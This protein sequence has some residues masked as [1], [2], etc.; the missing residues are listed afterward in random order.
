MY[1]EIDL[2]GGGSNPSPNPSLGVHG[3]EYHEPEVS[4]IIDAGDTN[5]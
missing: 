3:D 4:I 5:G 2:G 1:I